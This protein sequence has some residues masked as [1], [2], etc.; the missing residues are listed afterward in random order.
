MKV[1]NLFGGPGSGKSTT[2][3]GLFYQMKLKH[4]NVELITEY[5]KELVYQ[6]TLPVLK[7]Y[8]EFIF[9]EQNRRQQILEGKV[10]WAI[11]DSPLLFS[12]FYGVGLGRFNEDAFFNLVSDTFRMYDNVSFFLDRP[13]QFSQVGRDRTLEESIQIDNTLI[14]ILKDEGV[15]F[16]RLPTDNHTIEKIMAHLM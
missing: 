13:A 15:N 7:K 8:Q 4:M 9:A 16:I 5:A 12:H 1:I 3:A 2:A 11:T 6:D 10:D 14:K